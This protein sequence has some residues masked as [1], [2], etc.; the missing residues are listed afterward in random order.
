MGNNFGFIDQ[1][2]QGDYDSNNAAIELIN[3]LSS[4]Q[5]RVLVKMINNK[6]REA[7]EEMR[8]RGEIL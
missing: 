4:K 2:N 7:F 3:N 5:K 6:N 1:F 8:E